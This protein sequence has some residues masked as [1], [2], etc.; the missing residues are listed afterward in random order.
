[1]S[2]SGI[3]SGC[4]RG[5][6]KGRR[7]GHDGWW[8]AGLCAAAEGDDTEVASKSRSIFPAFHVQLNLG[9]SFLMN[10]RFPFTISLSI[11]Y[12]SSSFNLVLI[13]FFHSSD[14]TISSL[15]ASY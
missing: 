8:L 4:S 3:W 13:I 15:K 1:M 6:P 9:P 14:Y 11:L 7:N 2:G 10:L 5:Q 12:L